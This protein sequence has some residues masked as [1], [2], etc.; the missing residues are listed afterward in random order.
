MIREAPIT[1]RSQSAAQ[2]ALYGFRECSGGSVITQAMMED[3]LQGDLMLACRVVGMLE[4]GQE[5]AE[6]RELSLGLARALRNYRITHPGGLPGRIY[7]TFARLLL[8]EVAGGSTSTAE[9]RKLFRELLDLLA[10]SGRPLVLEAVVRMYSL[11]PLSYVALLQACLLR[12]R[13]RIAPGSQREQLALSGVVHLVAEQIAR[14]PHSP[15]ERALWQAH[16]SRLRTT[17]LP[18]PRYLQF[19]SWTGQRLPWI[20]RVRTWLSQA[21]FP[22]LRRGYAKINPLGTLVTLVAFVLALWADRL[23]LRVVG[24]VLVFVVLILFLVGA[25][26]GENRENC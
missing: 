7:E 18:Q 19:L 6:N 5:L 8:D 12:M 23:E 10:L 26:R 1:R 21:F 25:L 15:S 16:M 2:V 17:L 3:L 24:A 4:E 11:V 14:Q 20:H 13:S 9:D 22:A